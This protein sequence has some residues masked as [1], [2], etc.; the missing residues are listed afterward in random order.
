MRR[1][2][3]RE[4]T[5]DIL[6]L[7]ISHKETEARVTLAI[8][9][10]R[11]DEARILMSLDHICHIEGQ[12]PRALM[13]YRDLI[14]MRLLRVLRES[15]GVEAELKILKALSDTNKLQGED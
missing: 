3:I 2:K 6:A 10:G 8:N 7:M 15:A 5:S 1:S 12:L 11:Y 13:Q 9:L 4:L 14:T